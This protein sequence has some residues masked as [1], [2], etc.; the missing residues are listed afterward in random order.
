MSD[1]SNEN[2][3]NDDDLLVAGRSETDQDDSDAVDEQVAA[4]SDD[5]LAQVLTEVQEVKAILN[6]EDC[7]DY[8]DDEQSALRRIAPWAVAIAIVLGVLAFLHYKADH[9]HWSAPDRYEPYIG[10]SMTV[11]DA[12]KLCRTEC[13]EDDFVVLTYGAWG[14][15]A[16]VMYVGQGADFDIPDTVSYWAQGEIYAYDQDNPFWSDGIMA[17]GRYERPD[18]GTARIMRVGPKGLIMSF[19]KFDEFKEMDSKCPTSVSPNISGTFAD[20]RNR[21]VCEVPVVNQ[22]GSL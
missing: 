10:R 6:D 20:P 21:V 5:K 14:A 22:T 12:V 16:A 2:V 17:L 1:T 13:T 9:L 18:R 15:T 7:C 19:S 8:D 3:K 4:T 11:D